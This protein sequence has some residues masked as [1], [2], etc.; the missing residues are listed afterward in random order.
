MINV[1]ALDIRCRGVDVNNALVV[2][3]VDVET[4]VVAVTWFVV[5]VDIFIVLAVVAVDLVKC[6]KILIY[7]TPTKKL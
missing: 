7:V 3:I 1:E 4:L 2:V 6:T 5:L